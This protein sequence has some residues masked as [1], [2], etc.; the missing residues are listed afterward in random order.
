MSADDALPGLL[1][2]IEAVAG[3][4]A[5]LQVAKAVGGTRA[6]FP[7]EISKNHWLAQ[8]VGLDA[9]EAICRHFRTIGAGGERYGARHVF[10]PRGPYRYH[11]QGR[12]R[13]VQELILGASPRAAA[14]AA[15]MSERTAFRIKAEMRKKKKKGKRPHSKKSG[16]D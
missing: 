5:A 13:I 10:V 3:R 4:E 9:A 7:F 1:G 16:P 8:L 6:S 2:E 15:G 11:A 14:R 12:E